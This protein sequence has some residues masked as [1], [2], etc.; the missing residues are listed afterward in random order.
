MIETDEEDGQQENGSA[1][2]NDYAGEFLVYRTCLAV[3]DSSISD[4]SVI[5]PIFISRSSEH[6]MAVVPTCG[7]SNN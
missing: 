2:S 7:L 1:K 4:H 5:E 6:C 3:Q